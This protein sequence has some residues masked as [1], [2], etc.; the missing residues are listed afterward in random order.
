MNCREAE[1]R[2]YLYDELSSAEREETDVHLRGCAACSRIMEAV[3]LTRGVS[4]TVAPSHVLSDPAR[5]TARIMNALPQKRPQ[6]SRTS[7]YWSPG[8]ALR[9]GMAGV[10][11]L[12]IF[13][14][15]S[16]YNQNISLKT[17][18][19]RYPRVGRITLNTASFHEAFRAYKAE[20]NNTAFLYECAVNCLQTQGTVC[21]D[22]GIKFPKPNQTP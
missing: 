5:M 20:N 11:L 8:N 18:V 15:V 7:I 17:P 10:S 13:T 14:F 9:Y 3:T 2:I 1:K 4:R 21:A 12:L 6:A 19:K 22:C 16:E